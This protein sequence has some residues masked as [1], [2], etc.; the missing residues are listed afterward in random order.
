MCKFNL[1]DKTVP[2]IHTSNVLSTITEATSACIPEINQIHITGSEEHIVYNINDKNKTQVV[3]NLRNPPNMAWPKLLYISLTQK[4]I[5][6]G[7]DTKKNIYSCDMNENECDYAWKLND[8]EM[9]HYA[10]VGSY[11]LLLA[12]EQLVFCFYFA[13]DTH[14]EIW[15]FDVMQNTWF[16][17]CCD[18][19][20]SISQNT[21]VGYTHAF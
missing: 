17:A 6:F 1:K 14:C 2:V 18:L 7:S 5:A 21:D 8:I 15:I 10:I 12:F 9:P 20:S 13:E 16:R 4:L 19:P 11:D 3:E